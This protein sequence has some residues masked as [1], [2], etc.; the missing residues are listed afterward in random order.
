MK[1]INTYIEYINNKKQLQID[2]YSNIDCI[3]TYLICIDKYHY[4]EN[5]FAHLKYY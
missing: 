2:D 3:K 4:F 1:I 5:R